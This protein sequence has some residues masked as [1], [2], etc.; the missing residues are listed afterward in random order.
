AANEANHPQWAP[1][2]TTANNS[3]RHDQPLELQSVLID[4]RDPLVA[5]QLLDDVILDET[6]SAVDLD[7]R[8]DRAVGGF[9]GEQLRDARLIG[10]STAEV[11]QL[12]G[13]VCEEPSRLDLRRH[14]RDLPLDRLEV[15]DFL[16]EGVPVLRILDRFVEGPLGD[17]EGLGGDAG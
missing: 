8:I 13:A 9:G 10:V 17:P 7:R 1:G 6:V 2:I 16:T 15:C 12:G 3:K 5:V 11:L 4:L 14:V